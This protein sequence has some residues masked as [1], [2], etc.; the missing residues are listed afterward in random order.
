[1]ASTVFQSGKYF[2]SKLRVF[3]KRPRDCYA[4][5]VNEKTK[6]KHDVIYVRRPF[7]S[8]DAALAAIVGWEA[9]DEIG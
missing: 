3:L 6:E 4:A 8:I 7:V 9:V 2:V 5:G 1:M